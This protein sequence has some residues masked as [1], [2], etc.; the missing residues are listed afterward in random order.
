M[1]QY[2]CIIHKNK[3]KRIKDLN[4]S[5]ETI[6]LLNGKLLDTVIGDFLKSDTKKKG[7]ENKYKQVGLRETKKLLQTRENIKIKR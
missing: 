1:D 4:R 6:K 3:L 5:P 7:K 2:L